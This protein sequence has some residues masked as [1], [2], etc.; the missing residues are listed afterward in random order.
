M[1]NK[2]LFEI[3]G[4][5]REKEK[6][7]LKIKEYLTKKHA[8]PV[9][10][11]DKEYYGTWF[12]YKL[13]KAQVIIWTEPYDALDFF[14]NEEVHYDDCDDSKSPSPC[15]ICPA[16]RKYFVQ[17]E[18]KESIDDIVKDVKDVSGLIND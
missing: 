7:L 12:V 16:R 18:S 17:V 3:K 14:T 5:L 15:S 9:K 13:D 11:F 4:P 2:K 1:E 10:H 6:K 8:E